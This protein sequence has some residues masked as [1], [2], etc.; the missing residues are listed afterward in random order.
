DL[1]GFIE[2]DPTTGIY[3]QGSSYNIDN[4]INYASMSAQGIDI[5]IHAKTINGKIK[6]FTNAIF[7]T[8]KNKITR[9][10]AG[11]SSRITSYFPNGTSSP[12]V[13]GVSV[14]AMYSLPWKGISSLTGDPL[15]YL[16]GKESTSYAAYL[17]QLTYNDLI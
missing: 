1:I 8:S 3:K 7:N 6:W 12:P 9:Y 11:P 13:E 15:I 4:R 10:N 5:E 14:D 2:I 17:S 16:D